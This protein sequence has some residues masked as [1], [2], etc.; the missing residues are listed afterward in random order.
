MK[1]I[2]L[3][4]CV[5]AVALA[6]GAGPSDVLV[7]DPTNFDDEIGQ[8]KPAL[9][10]FYAPWCGHCKNLAPEWDIVATSFKGQP[11]I[12]ANVDADKHRELGSRFGVS[13]FPTIK[14]F[15]AGSKEGEAYNGGRTAPDI[16]DW[17]NKKAGTNVRV[18]GQQTAVTVLDP[19]NFDKIALDP[20]KD[21]LVEFYAPWCGHCKSLTPKYEKVAQSYEGEE[22]VVIA[23]VDADQHKDLGGRYKVSGFP[24]IKWFP[25]NNKD[26]ED[27][28]GGR[29]AE[30]FVKFINEK[31]GAQRALGRGFGEKAGRIDS[32]D[33]LAEKFG[34]A[35][36]DDAR[37][38]V[39][40]ETSAAVAALPAEQKEMGKVYESTM[41]RVIEKGQKA[42]FE[43]ANRLKRMIDGGSLS[44]KKKAEFYKRRNIVMLF[45][46]TE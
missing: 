38:S 27:Y 37:R 30:D 10:E 18:K 6:G 9:V 13:G 23:K 8:N 36:T 44:P 15:N 3:L 34:D 14:W 26:G 12:V 5:V 25:K 46:D 35:T 7:L 28:N 11:V 31:T 42:A 16:I 29:E 43:E 20:S 41:K 24:T 17:I 1:V 32:L 4:S 45:D 21:V 40:K 2:L 19:S 22:N 39:L 33:E